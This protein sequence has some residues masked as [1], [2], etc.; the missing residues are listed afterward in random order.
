MH[1]KQFLKIMF[2]GVLK[3]V[4]KHSRGGYKTVDEM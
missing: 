4:K 1:D 3:N 2:G